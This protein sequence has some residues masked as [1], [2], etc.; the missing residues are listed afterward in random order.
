MVH[1]HEREATEAPGPDTVQ[2]ILR[3]TSYDE[4]REHEA[5][6]IAT[7]ILEW[8][9]VLDRVAPPPA[10]QP[11]LRRVQTALGDRRGWL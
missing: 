10:A 2:H 9:S 5:E 11:D 7:I 1:G 8:A 3:R 6:L 4:A